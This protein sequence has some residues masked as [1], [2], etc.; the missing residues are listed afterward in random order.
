MGSS[1]ERGSL[2]CCRLMDRRSSTVWFGQ[3][4]KEAGRAESNQVKDP[5]RCS[6]AQCFHCGTPVRGASFCK[7]NKR[8][9]CQGCLTVYE[10]LTENGLSD[11]YNLASNAGVRVK[12]ATRE[13]QFAFLDEPSVRQR[14]VNFSNE[15]ITRVT[16]RLPA[17]HCI[18]CVWLLENL[19][20]LR[21]GI[22]ESQVNF[23]RKEVSIVFDNERVKLSE[24][25]ALLASLG[26]EPDLKFSDLEEQKDSKVPRRLW[27][28]LGVAGFA[29]GNI[30]LFSISSYLGLDTEQFQRLFG[31]LSFALALPV[32]FYS[33]ADYWKAAWIG[34]RQRLLTIEVP[35]A[36]GIIAIF[37]QSTYE[38]FTGTGEG[39]FDS[40]AGL[41]FFL[42]CGRLF[43]HKTYERLAFDR[44]YKSF[45]PISVIRKRGEKEESVSLSQVKA[46]D[47]LIIRNGELIPADATLVRGKAVIDYS[48]VTGESEPAAREPGD[49]LYAGG[50]Q[51]GEAIEIET[52]KEV[53]QSYLTSLWN[54]EAF[55]K[56][57]KGSLNTLTNQFS[58]RFTKL[59]FAVATIAAVYWMFADQSLALKAFVSVLIV[60]CPCALALAAPFSLGAGHRFLARR[61]VFLKAPSV[62]ETLAKVDSIVFDKTG[63]LTAA[64]AGSVVFQG[65]PLEPE[66]E[67][68]V[69]SLARQSTH[70]HSV[71]IGE[72][73]SHQ[74]S[75]P[76]R[77]FS[78]KTGC[79]I[80]GLAGGREIWMGSAAWFATRG[81]NV[82]ATDSGSSVVH[83][84]IDRRYRGAFVL[85]S[86]LRPGTG[87]LLQRLA[88][89]YE[90]A[91]LSGDNERQREQFTKLFGNTAALHFNQSPQKKLQFVGD[92]R[93]SSR[94]VM[95]VGDG[96]NDAGALKQSDV[97]VAVVENISAFSPACDVIMSA[98]MVPR[99]H[100]ILKFSKATVRVVRWS[101]LISTIYNVIGISIAASGKL[102]P[103]VCAVLM[104]ISSV[105][106]VV[107]ACGMTTWMGR[108]IFEQ[109]DRETEFI[110][111]PRDRALSSAPLNLQPAEEV[112]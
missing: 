110:P 14:L 26:Y 19:F 33:A 47:R 56:E 36:A 111:A 90:L 76:V 75:E 99:L 92:L 84:A 65:L 39:Y 63:T 85:T 52:A 49:H 48:F 4:D 51:V 66:E 21:P 31:C 29:F 18:A 17:I 45:F 91:L 50:R 105:T 107:F 108:R 43:Q 68:A 35:I 112:A 97:G 30:M 59:V 64:G 25:V 34:L 12:A 1:L 42:N 8:F 38:V 102:A 101:F 71:R 87:K 69:F 41:L 7:E 88:A 46:G 40:L 3:E 96:L 73:L 22:G 83:L 55:R 104:P 109:A 58:Y 106:V 93:D 62:I 98:G 86:A 2:D 10:L 70:P 24:L 60:A 72:L 61:N 94:T 11:F 16:F 6:D 103:V 44:D 20:R 80:E 15:K 54:Q 79:G 89:N 100:E 81:L 82:P 78:E 74:T 95:M 77:S 37:G 28:Q 67:S 5:V 32:V 57:K 23:P 13:E 27:L 53:S 9:C